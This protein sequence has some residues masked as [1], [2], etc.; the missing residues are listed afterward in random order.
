MVYSLIA[1]FYRTHY[2]AFVAKGIADLGR[3]RRSKDLPGLIGI[4]NFFNFL[5]ISFSL[6]I[7]FKNSLVNVTDIY[8]FTFCY[9]TIQDN[10]CV[11]NEN[12]NEQLLIGFYR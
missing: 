3:I 11:R 5:I 10:Q 12:L 1:I 4:R 9:G 6:S 8:V 7:P 2:A